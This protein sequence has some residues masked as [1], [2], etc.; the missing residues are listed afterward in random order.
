MVSGN[1]FAGRSYQQN[2]TRAGHVLGN[3]FLS[4]LIRVFSGIEMRDALSGMRVFSK[5]FISNWE[6]LSD[7]FQLETEFSIHC[8]KNALKYGELEIEYSERD[9]GDPSKLNSIR[10]GLK[11]LRFAIFN[12]VLSL[13]SRIGLFLSVVMGLLAI[14]F[15]VLVI[16][17]YLV[18]GFVKSVATAVLVGMLGS[19]ALLLALVSLMENRLRRIEQLLNR[20]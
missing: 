4:F 15:A 18:F 16:K 20:K 14:F 19:M 6:G 13:T 17:E 9:A 8:G 1:R 10:D 12:A 11:I 3:I 2:D 7:G 5:R